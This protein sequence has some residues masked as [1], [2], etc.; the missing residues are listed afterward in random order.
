MH[1]VLTIMFT[2]IKG[3]TERTSMRTRTE[4]HKLLKKHS[5]ILTPIIERCLGYIVKTIGDAYMVAFESPTNAVICGILIQ[6]ALKN[7]NENVTADERFEIRI[8]INSGECEILDGDVYGEPVNIAARIETI[9]EA[10]EIYFTESV[11][12]AMQ[13]SE[14]PSTEIGYRTLKGVPQEVKVYK[15]LRDTKDDRYRML[16][17]KV[18]KGELISYEKPD[19]SIF[20][21]KRA[22]RNKLIAVVVTAVLITGAIAVGMYEM[23]GKRV[24]P[25]NNEIKTIKTEVEK[26]KDKVKNYLDSEKYFSVL[27]KIEDFIDKYPLEAGAD[28]FYMEV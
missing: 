27:G 19:F 28:G 5:E 9:T 21:G 26:L 24:K 13:K 17:E 16:L 14:V 1:K 20:L 7:Y 8:A 6:H 2:D 25:D 4:L 18:Q 11:Y 22:V 12:L 23:L 15:V 10:N 3:Y